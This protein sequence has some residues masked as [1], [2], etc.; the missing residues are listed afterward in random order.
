[1]GRSVLSKVVVKSQGSDAD[2][3]AP[4]LLREDFVV[5]MAGSA[6]P[7]ASKT[8]DVSA[9]KRQRT[10]KV[11][12]AFTLSL[13]AFA[14]INAGIAYSPYARVNPETTSYHSW[15]WWTVNDIRQATK[16]ANVVL[17]GSSLMVAAVAECDANF[18]KHSLDLATYRGASYLDKVLHDKLD[19][20][21]NTMN[22][23][24]PGQM[25]SDAYLTLNA[26]L[27]E[28]MKP[29]VIVYGLAPRDFLDGTMQ[30]PSDTEAFKYLRRSVDISDCGFDYYSSPFGK[31]DWLLQRSVNLYGISLDCRLALE[32]LSRQYLSHNGLIN[33]PEKEGAA[34]P[35]ATRLRALLRPF[36]IEPGTFL[37]LQTVN[38]KSSMIDNRRDYMD[39]YRNP[40]HRL[41]ETQFRFLNRI[42]NRCEKENI[43]LVLVQM[44]ITHENVEILKPAVYSNYKADLAKLCDDKKISLLDLCKFDQYSKNDYRDTVHLNGFGG[45]KFVDNLVAAIGADNQLKTSVT[46]AGKVFANH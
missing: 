15:T 4:S 18:L 27:N 32:R 26:A 8:K 3:I 6:H 12:S 28:G 31:L 33:L 30:S 1:M 19:G 38:D 29:N 7:K 23:S 11:L 45:K 10:S 2:E 43:K 5:P 16:P 17:L 35:F 41:Y 42:V 13:V 14:A 46:T 22:L 9:N 44:P 20:T 21:F 25:P 37:A 40:D 34:G 39:R 36:N 24:A